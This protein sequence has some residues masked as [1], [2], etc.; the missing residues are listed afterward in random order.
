[1]NIKLHERIESIKMGTAY[2]QRFLVDGNFIIC[3]LMEGWHI[4]SFGVAKRNPNY[5]ELDEERGKEIS[6]ARAVKKL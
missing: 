2:S 3:L 6:L 4:K 1:M 5:D